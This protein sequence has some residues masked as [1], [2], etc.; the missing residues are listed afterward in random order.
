MIELAAGIRGIEGFVH[1]LFQ[2]GGASPRFPD[3]RCAM[4]NQDC[5]S[6]CLCQWGYF[7][8]ISDSTTSFR[9][10]FRCGAR[11]RRITWGK[12]ERRYY[13]VRHRNLTPTIVR[14]WFSRR[15]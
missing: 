10:I 14:R 6:A 15:F 7:C 3:L 5:G 4:L 8:Q 1:R 13:A 11:M 12:T 2:I 9:F